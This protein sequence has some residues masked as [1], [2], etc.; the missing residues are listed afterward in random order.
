[1]Q[2]KGGDNKNG[3]TR[4][5]NTVFVI[6][7]DGINLCHLGDLGHPLS[8]HL[9]EE[10][11]SVDVLFVP[12]GEISTISVDTAVELVRQL[13]PIIVIPMHYRTHIYNNLEPVDKFLKRMGIHEEETRPKLSLTRSSLPTNMQIVVLSCPQS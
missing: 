10:I 4:G 2:H 11:G 12:A 3:E 8:P 13:N 7:I 9:L 5:K 6:E 1:M